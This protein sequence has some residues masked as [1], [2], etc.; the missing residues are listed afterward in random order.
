LKKVIFIM[1]AG[2]SGST[3][4]DLIIGS[5]SKAFSLGE[6]W[7][8]SADQVSKK[9]SLICGV[10]AGECAFWN[11][12]ASLPVL[13]SYFGRWNRSNRLAFALYRYLGGFKGNIYRHLLEWSRAEVLVDSSKRVWWIRRQL[14][15]SWFWRGMNP[16][17]IYLHRDGRAVANSLLRK[18]P[19]RGMAAIAKG[20]VRGTQQRERYFRAFPRHRRLQLAYEQLATDPEGVI[21]SVCDWLDIRYEPEMLRYWQHD[22]HPVAG[23]LGA[24]SLIFKYREQFDGGLAAYWSQINEGDRYTNQAHYDELGMAIKLDLRWRHELSREQLDI[25][26]TVAG[27]VNRPYAYEG[28]GE[29]NV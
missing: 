5:H 16:F 12:R 4:L 14:L 26:D 28:T 24:R 17:L 21:N 25:F 3:L 20:W 10:C 1:G 7:S 29:A 23:N 15:P 8:I 11:R 19:E 2:H 9:Q 18:F 6:L 13:R 27:A 22:H